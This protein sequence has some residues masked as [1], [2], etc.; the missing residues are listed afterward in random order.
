VE[1]K[2]SLAQI[3]VGDTVLARYEEVKKIDSYGSE[4]I[5]RVAKVIS[6][7]RAAEKKPESTSMI[8]SEKP[9]EI[10]EEELPE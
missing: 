9:Q 10:S 4:R 3:S 6:F 8:S 2:S 1:R 7:V 5:E